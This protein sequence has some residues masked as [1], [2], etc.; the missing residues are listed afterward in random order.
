MTIH[1]RTWL[2]NKSS[3]FASNSSTVVASL[4]TYLCHLIFDTYTIAIKSKNTYK[5]YLVISE[6]QLSSVNVCN[7]TE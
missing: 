7:K 5:S 2:N 3:F 1:N 6:K 4:A